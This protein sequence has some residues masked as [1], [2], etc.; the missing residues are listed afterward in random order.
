MKEIKIN[1]K[2]FHPDFNFKD[3]P[4]INILRQHYKVT[5]S[6]NPDYIFYSI[7]NAENSFMGEQKNF[8]VGSF[9][10]RWRMPELKGDFA[11][12]F[13]TGENC[14]PDMDKCD[15]AFTP[16]LDK[17]VNHPRHTRITPIAHSFANSTFPGNNTK[18]KKFCCFI[19]ANSISFRDDFFKK[20]STYKRVDAPGVCMNNMHP[21]NDHN[22]P[23]NSRRS[24]SWRS[25]I[26]DF[27]KDYKFAI[28][29]ENSSSPG[30][31][32]EKIYHALYAG[33]IPIYWG[34]PYVEKDIDAKWFINYH[35][36]N[37]FRDLLKR[38]VEIDNDDDLCS[39][40]LE[41]KKIPQIQ[42]QLDALTNSFHQ[43]F[44]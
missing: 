36:Y 13:F 12:I 19:Y 23:T 21:I 34:N 7:C 40:Y 10:N 15:W 25:E 43:I 16:C 5:V 41:E 27:M 26:I 6:N 31:T 9:H 2:H 11:K 20:L 33:C 4:A 37:K 1:F 3:N 39:S 32:T 24:A 8:S 30:Y 28:T 17:Y 18:K 35:R 38:I 44:D 22:S 29:F 42:E 14:K